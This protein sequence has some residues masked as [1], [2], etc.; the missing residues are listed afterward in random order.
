VERCIRTLKELLRLL[1]LTPMRAAAFRMELQLIVGWHKSHR[2]HAGLDGR[3]P[4]ELYFR[5]FPANRRPR[6]ESRAKWPKGSSCAKPWALIRGQPGA[7]LELDVTLHAGRKH[8]PVIT[9]KRVAYAARFAA[10]ALPLR[11]KRPHGALFTARF[12]KSGVVSI[13]REAVFT[14]NHATRTWFCRQ[15]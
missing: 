14:R 12:S 8:L 4:D 1:V 5:T 13:C 15:D 7:R 6:H 11:A 2:P 10:S 9:L 3:T